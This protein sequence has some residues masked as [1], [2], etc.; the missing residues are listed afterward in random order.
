MKMPFSNDKY[1]IFTFVFQGNK[2]LCVYLNGQVLP[3]A[4]KIQEIA[5]TNYA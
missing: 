3:N 2:V 4:E 5:T 1:S